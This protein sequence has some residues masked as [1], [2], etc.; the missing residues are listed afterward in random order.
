MPP[1]TLHV[2]GWIADYAPIAHRIL[3][4]DA[5]EGPIEGDMIQAVVQ[6][7]VSGCEVRG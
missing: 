3:T 5:G 2:M 7:L 4:F 1:N 6:A